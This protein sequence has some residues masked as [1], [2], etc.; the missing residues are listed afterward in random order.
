MAFRRYTTPEDVAFHDK[1]H[2]KVVN[3]CDWIASD[4]AKGVTVLDS[5]AECL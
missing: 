4:E 1:H 5:S 3:G 2:K